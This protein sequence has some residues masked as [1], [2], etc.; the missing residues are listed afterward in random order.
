MGHHRLGCCVL[1]PVPP[2]NELAAAFNSGPGCAGVPL[3][4]TLSYEGLVATTQIGAFSATWP[5]DCT[6]PIACS[7]GP[8]VNSWYFTLYTNGNFGSPP[9]CSVGCGPGI[10]PNFPG[11]VGVPEFILEQGWSTQGSIRCEQQPLPH[12]VV[13]LRICIFGTQ[14]VTVDYETPVLGGQTAPPP[15]VYTFRDFFTDGATVVSSLPA[16]C[17]V[18]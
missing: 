14:C 4:L 11:C 8:V 15:G 1:P 9:G 12:W 10:D 16:T 5:E 2:C 6:V 17:L 7:L 13:R 3:V 18:T